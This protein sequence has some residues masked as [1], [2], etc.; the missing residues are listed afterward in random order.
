MLVMVV[1]CTWRWLGVNVVYFLSG[2]QNIPVEQYESASI[3][4]ANEWQKLMRITVPGLK[5]VI[6][7]VV[8]ISVY[9]GYAMFSNHT[10]Y[11]AQDRRAI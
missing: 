2:L 6:V 10:Y 9:G 4:G 7:Y 11:S 5:P 3:D 1:L 8:T